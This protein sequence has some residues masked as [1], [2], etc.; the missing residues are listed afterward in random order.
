MFRVQ[1][2]VWKE[3]ICVCRTRLMWAEH[4]L[5]TNGKCIC[6]A[7]QHNNKIIHTFSIGLFPAGLFLWPC[8]VVCDE[9]YE[10][11]WGGEIGGGGGG[12]CLVQEQKLSEENTFYSWDYL[13]LSQHAVAVNVGTIDCAHKSRFSLSAYPFSATIFGCLVFFYCGGGLRDLE[14]WFPVKLKAFHIGCKIMFQFNWM[15]NNVSIQTGCKI[16]FQFKLDAK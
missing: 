16:T 4:C 5:S 2:H 7:L 10:F 1:F 14:V 12:H 6:F 3:Q 13:T 15:Q 11:C 9:L 8:C